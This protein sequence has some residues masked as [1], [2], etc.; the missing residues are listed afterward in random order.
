MAAFVLAE[1]D[2]GFN[3]LVADAKADRDFLAL[4]AVFERQ[5]RHVSPKLSSAYAPAV[6]AKHPGAE[7]VSKKAFELAME[8]LLTAGRIQVDTVG[9][10]SK[11]SQK[12]SIAQPGEAQ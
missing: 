8:R 3:K 6:F 11:R 2:G 9:P 7:G 4:L 12:L 1:L 5:G 10:P